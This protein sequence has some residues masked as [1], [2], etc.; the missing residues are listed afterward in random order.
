MA[1]PVAHEKDSG[2][3]SLRAFTSLESL[4]TCPYTLTD[5]WIMCA[6]SRTDETLPKYFPP[7]LKELLL[8]ES[9]VPSVTASLVNR[10][11][12]RTVSLKDLR[13]KLSLYTH[14]LRQFGEPDDL[15]HWHK[16]RYSEW[17]DNVIPSA[18]EKNINLTLQV[19]ECSGKSLEVNF[20]NHLLPFEDLL[21]L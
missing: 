12:E 14:P 8:E 6:N 3:G 10:L 19:Q 5:K 4:E 15:I 21:F 7:S 1:Q 2:L 9:G 13:I 18:K 17:R 20:R 16:W 11:V